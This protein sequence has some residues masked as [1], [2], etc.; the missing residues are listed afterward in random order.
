MSLH[1]TL[2][3]MDWGHFQDTEPQIVLVKGQ[4]KSSCIEIFYWET[5]V[6]KNEAIYRTKMRGF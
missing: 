6:L 4:K 5:L 1:L 3:A 2:S